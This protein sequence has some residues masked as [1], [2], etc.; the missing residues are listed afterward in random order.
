MLL[1]TAVTT[2]GLLQVVLSVDCLCSCRED[3]VRTQSSFHL[4]YIF[5]IG[6]FIRQTRTRLSAGVLWSPSC[7]KLAA[8]NSGT[9][10]DFEV[11]ETPAGGGV[12]RA[13]LKRHADPA[14]A[15]P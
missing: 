1:Y 5:G 11:C 14:T 10:V 8:F 2:S 13:R 15:S 4:S 6:N 7:G 9:R 12:A 3:N